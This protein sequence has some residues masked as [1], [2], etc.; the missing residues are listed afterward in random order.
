M[1]ISIILLSFIYQTQANLNYR[2]IN[3]KQ[4][5]NGEINALKMYMCAFAPERRQATRHYI[6][7][8]A[9]ISL[10]GSTPEEEGLHISL[11]LSDIIINISPATI[12]LLNKAMNSISTG[13]AE[14]AALDRDETDYSDIWYS[15]P[16]KPRNFWFTRAEKAVDALKL[17]H[18]GISMSHK[19]EKCVIEVPNITVV[20]ESGVGYYTKP[21]ISLDT[22][23]TAV[24]NDW[25]RNLSANGSLTLNMVK[26]STRK[27]L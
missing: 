24:F 11:K 10:Q 20:L 4:I 2:A 17:E 12:E 6:L 19:T 9:T 18:E 8:P 27:S 13:S 15:R 21:L 26:Y 16:F 25:S 1:V 14:K 22:R 3:D 5:I 7:H 23:M